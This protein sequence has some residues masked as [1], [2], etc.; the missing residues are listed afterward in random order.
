[1]MRKEWV[2]GRL[3]AAYADRVERLQTKTRQQPQGATVLTYEWEQLT[4]HYQIEFGP[5][6]ERAAQRLMARRLLTLAQA[7]EIVPTL[8]MDGPPTALRLLVDWMDA[9]PESAHGPVWLKAFEAGYQ[10]HLFGML[11]RAPVKPQ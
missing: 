9:F 2:A 10:D 3:P 1:F 6:R 8:L 11:L 4:H 7:L 5:R